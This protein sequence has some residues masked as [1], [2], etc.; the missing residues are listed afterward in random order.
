MQEMLPFS[1]SESAAIGHFPAEELEQ[2][3]GRNAW[4]SWPSSDVCVN[5]MIIMGYNRLI[6]EDGV[7]SV[8]SFVSFFQRNTFII[9]SF[10]CPQS[11]FTD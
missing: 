8:W 4:E 11:Y 5:I 3:D 9:L 1:A 7:V 6:L 10:F 2:F